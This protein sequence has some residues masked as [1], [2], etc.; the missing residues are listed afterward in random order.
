MKITQKNE[1]GKLTIALE[2]WLDNVSAP[3]LGEVVDSIADVKEIVLDF[4]QVE[5]ISSAGIRQLVSAY[6]KAKEI[7][8]NLQIIHVNSE[9]MSILSMTGI[10]K[11]MNFS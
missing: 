5:Y 6:R 4:A 3:E 2:G 7:E 10:D 8:A 11:K 1:D 9:V